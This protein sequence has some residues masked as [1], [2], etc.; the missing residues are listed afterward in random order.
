MFVVYYKSKK[1][2]KILSNIGV[3][4]LGCS[5]MWWDLNHN[6]KHHPFVNTRKDFDIHLLDGVFTGKSKGNTK[7]YI[8]F[9]V[10]ALALYSYFILESIKF[11]IKHRII[12]EGVAMALYYVIIW[13]PLILKYTY[14]AIPMFIGF[15]ILMSLWMSIVFATNHLGMPYKDK[16]NNIK[17][18]IE[19]SRSLQYNI[20][21]NWVFGGLNFHI[22]H[23]L[24]PTLSRFNMKEVQLDVKHFC[25]IN[26]IHYQEDSVYS[27]FSSINK[28]LRGIK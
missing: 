16:T 28:I 10:G 12:T 3:Y 19:V 26:A 13:L 15:H 23:H 24:F 11:T 17:H 5:V 6:K 8:K 14:V 4:L 9:W 2:S 21:V 20:F 22:E 27:A 25:K 7:V 18:Q 1:L